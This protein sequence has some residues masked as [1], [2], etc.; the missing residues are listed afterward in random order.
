[1]ETYTLTKNQIQK[2]FER[3]YAD[4]KRDGI[5]KNAKPEN[6]TTCFIDYAKEVLAK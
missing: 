2:I 3:W 4:A 6:S 5:D 1:M